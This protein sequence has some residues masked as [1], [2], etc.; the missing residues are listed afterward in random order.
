MMGLVAVLSE[1]S[2]LKASLYLL[3]LKASARTIFVFVREFWQTR[4]DLLITSKRLN[5]ES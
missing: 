2:R 5:A 3:G 4:I 1:L